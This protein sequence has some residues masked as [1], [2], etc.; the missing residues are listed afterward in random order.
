[1]LPATV[2]AAAIVAVNE[3]TA[4]TLAPQH[5]K[6]QGADA[7][8][9][10]VADEDPTTSTANEGDGAANPAVAEDGEGAG[11]GGSRRRRGRRG[12]RRRRRGASD[13]LDSG[14]NSGA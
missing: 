9:P 14:E 10:M 5:S 12:G 8:Q 6:P 11:D 2:A 1:T 4:T 7:A 13:N 3:T